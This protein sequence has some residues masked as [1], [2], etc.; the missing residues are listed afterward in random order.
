MR[1]PKLYTTFQIDIKKG[2][3]Y[4]ITGGTRTVYVRRDNR[5]LHVSLGGYLNGK[6]AKGAKPEKRRS[7][8]SM[9][10]YLRYYER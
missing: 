7:R 1:M 5:G 10:D 6:K 4:R 2:E 8:M 9:D 3:Q